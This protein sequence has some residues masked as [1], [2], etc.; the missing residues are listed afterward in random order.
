M[1]NALL[2]LLV[3]YTINQIHLPADL[4]IPGVNVANLLFAG[5]LALVLLRGDAAPRPP[6][7]LG[8]PLRAYFLLMA[9]GALIGIATRPT[10]LMSDLTYLKTIIFYPLYYFLFYYAVDDLRSARRLVLAILAVAVVAGLEAWSE[11]RAYGLGGYS[12]THRASGPFG[13]DYRTANR[14]GVFYAML[15][16]MFVAFFLFARHKLSWRMLGAVGALVLVGGILVTYSRQS[17]FIGLLAI[18]L[19][20]WRRGIGTTLLAGLVFAIALP[21]LPQGAFE[22]VEE[23]QQETATGEERYDESTESRWELWQGAFAMWGENPAGVGLNRFK[24]EIGNYSG[25]SGKDAHNFYVLTLAEAGPQGVIA[26]L[27]LVF[28]MWRL[29]RWA[30]R[31]ADDAESRALTYGF[32]V[33]LVG[34]ALGN[35]Y[36]SPFSEGSVMCAIWA[37]CAIIE[38]YT[39]LRMQQAWHARQALQEAPPHFDPARRAG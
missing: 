7:R 9:L 39:Q 2:A 13:P 11:A 5:V 31:H 36:G 18:L 20:V 27:W 12:E 28:S 6:S 4:G 33:A 37:L 17:Y 24:Q 1:L 30:A 22:R 19:L 21:F 35:V 23:T 32:S 3:L 26:L 10:D 34:M 15:L 16:P 14:A 29:A 38:R 25:Y 8:G